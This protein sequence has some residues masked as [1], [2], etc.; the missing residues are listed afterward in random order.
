MR[1]CFTLAGNRVGVLALLPERGHGRRGADGSRKNN[2]RYACR[3]AGL[4]QLDPPTASTRPLR[5]VES[6]VRDRVKQAYGR[7]GAS[8]LI[9]VH[10]KLWKRQLR[11][12]GVGHHRLGVGMRAPVPDTAAC[13]RPYGAR[14]AQAESAS[15]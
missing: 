12:V 11:E 3:R 13:A 5:L 9:P 10:R 4:V 1:V 7:A 15:Q 8:Y 2:E 6:L 14:G